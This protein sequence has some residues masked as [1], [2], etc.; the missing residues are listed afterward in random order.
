MGAQVE[1]VRKLNR[2]IGRMAQVMAP[3]QRRR[4]L[5][6]TGTAIIRYIH[7][8][9]ARETA[10]EWPAPGATAAQSR[11]ANAWAGEPWAPLAEST[12][13]R[14][15]KGRGRGR[16]GGGVRILQDTGTLRRSIGMYA[17]HEYVEVGAGQPYGKHHQF[18]GRRLPARPFVGWAPAGARDFET[19][20]WRAIAKA[21]K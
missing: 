3:H 19:L 11:V 16:G 21:A 18:G 4:F 9:F 12:I 2:A 5:V 20:V 17:T 6:F 13:R 7:G 8:C 1:G 15:R 14:R 10:P